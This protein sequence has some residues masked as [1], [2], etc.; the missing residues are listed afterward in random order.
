MTKTQT[1]KKQD[2]G[3]KIEPFFCF[4]MIYGAGVASFGLMRI[5]I[6]RWSREN[7]SGIY[8]VLFWTRWCYLV[9]KNWF[10]VFFGH[11]Y[12]KMHIYANVCNVVYW[13][14]G[15]SLDEDN[16]DSNTQA[17]IPVYITLEHN[18]IDFYLT[19]TY[20]FKSV[21]WS[22]KFIERSMLLTA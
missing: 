1:P 3:T 2:H 19:L 5:Q 6:R 7:S 9:L 12:F 17:L 10:I 18:I 11:N 8:G 14:G 20:S 13:G 21:T 15:E 22:W 4:S 16:D